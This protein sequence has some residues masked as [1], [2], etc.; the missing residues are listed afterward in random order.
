MLPSYYDLLGV[1]SKATDAE[2]K[3]AFRARAKELHPD[4]SPENKA[5]QHSRF[6]ELAEAYDVLKD[7]SRRRQYD[8]A[9]S[10]FP[11]QAPVKGSSAFHGSDFGASAPSSTDTASEDAFEATFKRWW[12]RAGAD[13]ERRAAEERYAPNTAEYRRQQAEAW[14]AEKAEAQLN[15][16]RFERIR[17]R[18]KQARAVRQAAVMRGAWQ[19][20]TGLVWADAFVAAAAAAAAVGLAAFWAPILASADA[21]S[22]HEAGGVP[23]P[24]SQPAS[25]EHQG[26]SQQ[27]VE[28]GHSES[29]PVS[30]PPQPSPAA[31][32]GKMQAAGN[33][34]S[35]TGM[36]SQRTGPLRGIRPRTGSTLN[37]TTDS[38]SS[39]IQ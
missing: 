22:G 35:L 4:S 3:T 5:S 34:A 21:T 17:L 1:D 10:V 36:F 23:H 26:G 28:H 9:R 32:Q 12:E 38:R 30:M 19:T 29:A 27:T 6:V 15:K 33:G 8:A 24:L 37:V 39:P 16:A 7:K 14:E 13:W 31:S 2:V 11:Q 20:R 18:T 25:K